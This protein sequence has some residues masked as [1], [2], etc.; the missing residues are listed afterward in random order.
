MLTDRSPAMVRREG[1]VDS[2]SSMSSTIEPARIH[3]PRPSCLTPSR[4]RLHPALVPSPPPPRSPPPPFPPA[5]LP[6]SPCP[7]RLL[8]LC[9]EWAIRQVQTSPP[10]SI[11]LAIFSPLLSILSSHPM[12]RN[13][14]HSSSTPPSKTKPTNAPLTLVCPLHLLMLPPNY[15]LNVATSTIKSHTNPKKCYWEDN[16]QNIMIDSTLRKNCYRFKSVTRFFVSCL[17]L[18]TSYKEIF[19]CVVAMNLNIYLFFVSCV[20]LRLLRIYHIY[21]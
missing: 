5:S 14:S 4:R 17:R 8:P 20:L 18:H 11:I 21:I 10:S 12:T 2:R 15:I 6:N 13:T 16:S 19:I 3:R 9:P 1:S 7:P